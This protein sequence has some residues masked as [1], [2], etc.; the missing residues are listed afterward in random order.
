MNVDIRASDSAGDGGRIGRVVSPRMISRRTVKGFTIGGGYRWRSPNII[1]TSAGGIEMKGRAITAADLMV[2]YK[3]R[4]SEGRLKGYLILQMNVMNLFDEG[5]TIPT[6]ISSTTDFIVPAGR[7]IGDETLFIDAFT[8]L[9][10][11][12]AL[13][14]APG[15][16]AAQ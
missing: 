7:G 14:T 13:G 6:H 12:A 10:R 16:A 1:G 15:F 5:R 2:R 9:S 8:G 11:A 3:R 4:L